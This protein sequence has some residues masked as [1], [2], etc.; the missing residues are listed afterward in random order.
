MSA[1]KSKKIEMD[2][3]REV[4]NYEDFEALTSE[5]LHSRRIM[6]STPKAKRIKST[7]EKLQKYVADFSSK[8]RM[9]KFKMYDES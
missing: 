2:K 1:Q 3:S 6:I 4:Q 8:P 9:K 7:A 5:L